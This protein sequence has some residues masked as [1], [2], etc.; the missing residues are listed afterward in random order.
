[1]EM[2]HKYLTT[3]NI[4]LLNKKVSKGYAD[5]YWSMVEDIG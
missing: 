1:M 2:L 4:V 5:D 3:M